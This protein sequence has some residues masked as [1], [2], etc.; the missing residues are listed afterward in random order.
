MRNATRSRDTKGRFIKQGG[1]MQSDEQFDLEKARLSGLAEAHIEALRTDQEQ[2]HIDMWEM[3]DMADRI[4]DAAGANEPDELQR[5][6]G[7]W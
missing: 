5:I 6:R 4:A 3:A 1:I 7:R 2:F